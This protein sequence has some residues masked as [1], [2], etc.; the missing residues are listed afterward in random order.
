ML[1]AS[2]SRRSYELKI[3]SIEG[4][5]YLERMY[6]IR[7]PVVLV[8]GVEVFEAKDMDL[9]GLWARKLEGI[10]TGIRIEG[11]NPRRL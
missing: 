8:D 11:E 9:H 2:S 4:D 5:W 1:L 7:I 10:L 6:M 3:S